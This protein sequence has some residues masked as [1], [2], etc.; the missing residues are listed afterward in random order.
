LS[1]NLRI[2]VASGTQRSALVGPRR[3]L[4][5]LLDLERF[6]VLNAIEH[7]A[8]ELQKSGPLT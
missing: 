3:D 2:L 8:A 4:S 1:K 6:D 5:K 7:T